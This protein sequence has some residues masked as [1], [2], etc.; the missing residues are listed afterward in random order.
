VLIFSQKA[1]DNLAGLVK[2]IDEVQKN[3]SKLGTVVVGVSGVEGSDLEKLQET[4]KLTTP[5]TVAVAEDG[6]KAY[7]LNKDAAVTVLVYTKGGKVSKNFAFSDTKSA[8]EKAKEIGDAAQEAIK[9]GSKEK[10]K[11]KP[12]DTPKKDPPK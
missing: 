5:L 10:P 4:H 8:L 6:P 1:D 11:D 3:N 12:K 7:K 2:S 9:E